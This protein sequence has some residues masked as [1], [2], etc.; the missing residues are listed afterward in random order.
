MENE[1]ALQSTS[2]ATTRL[3]VAVPA[4]RHTNAPM[5]PAPKGDSASTPA[6]VCDKKQGPRSIFSPASTMNYSRHST[7]FHYSSL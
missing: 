1:A 7:K 6:C 4:A 2:S 5:R 3:L